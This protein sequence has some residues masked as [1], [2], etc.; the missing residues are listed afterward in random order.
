[1]KLDSA[2]EDLVEHQLDPVTGSG[3][4]C[5]L[6]GSL[7]RKKAREFAVSWLEAWNLGDLARIIVH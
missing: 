1:M 7:R 5:C 2:P 3:D 6:P 4:T